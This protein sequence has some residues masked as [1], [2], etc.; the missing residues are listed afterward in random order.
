MQVEAEA[1]ASSCSDSLRFLTTA[2]LPTVG[3]LVSMCRHVSCITTSLYLA[4][5]LGLALDDPRCPAVALDF[6]DAAS[7]VKAVEASLRCCMLI[8]CAAHFVVVVFL[9]DSSPDRSAYCS[10]GLLISFRSQSALRQVAS[11][12]CGST[13]CG[14]GVQLLPR[15]E[16][17][18]AATPTL[19]QAAQQQNSLTVLRTILSKPF[20]QTSLRQICGMHKPSQALQESTIP[21][22]T[23][24]KP[25]ISPITCARTTQAARAYCPATQVT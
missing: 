7:M 12:H 2:I 21:V 22:L 9:M 13:H 10:L 23:H 3:K 5:V 20:C 16:D 14:S 17:L 24:L 15:P 25:Q 11:A 6:Q 18:T 19:V 8:A 1:Q 4:A